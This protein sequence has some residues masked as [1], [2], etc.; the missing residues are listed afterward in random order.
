MEILDLVVGQIENIEI[1]GGLKTSKLIDI[2]GL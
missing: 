1:D 2:V